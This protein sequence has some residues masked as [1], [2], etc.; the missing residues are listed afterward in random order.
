MFTMDSFG[1]DLPSNWEAL[2]DFLNAKAAATIGPDD[3]QHDAENDLWER[4]CCGDFDNDPDFPGYD[5]P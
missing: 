3:D 4:F 1:S 2:C 5:L